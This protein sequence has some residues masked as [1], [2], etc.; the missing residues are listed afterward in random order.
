MRRNRL[1][2]LIWLDTK[3]HYIGLANVRKIFS[4]EDDLDPVSIHTPV[5]GSCYQYQFISKRRSESTRQRKTFLHSSHSVQF[6]FFLVLA[7]TF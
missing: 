5:P 7:L 4:M 2:L 1:I 6:V 3:P